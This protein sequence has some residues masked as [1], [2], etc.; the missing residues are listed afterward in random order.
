MPH[1]RMAMLQS[2]PS[3]NSLPHWR[4]SVESAKAL[5]RFLIAVKPLMGIWVHQNPELGNLVYVTWGFVSIVACRIIPQELGPRGFDT[6]LLWAPVFEILANRDGTLVFFLHGRERDQNFLY[7]GRFMAANQEPNV[8]VLEAEPLLNSTHQLRELSSLDSGGEDSGEEEQVMVKRKGSKGKKKASVAADPVPFHRLAFG[9]RRRLLEELA[10]QVRLPVPPQAAYGPLFFSPRERKP[11][12]ASN[13]SFQLENA[14]MAERR[15]AILSAYANS[16][17]PGSPYRGVDSV[18]L[19]RSMC[20]AAESLDAIAKRSSASDKPVP[21]VHNRGNVKCASP[22]SE[23]QTDGSSKRIGFA[24]FVRS[25]LQQIVGKSTAQ[26]SPKTNPLS[27]TEIKRLQFEEF[28]K[29]GKAVGLRLQA[30]TWR[31]SFY[32]AWPIMYDNRFALYKIPEQ[33]RVEGREHAGLWGGTFGWPP[34]RPAHAKPGS[35]LFFLLLS[36]DENE[37]GLHLIATKV[38]EGTHY[39][40]HPNGSAMFT[41][42]INEPSSEEFPFDINSEGSVLDIV[43]TWQGEGIANGYG[44]RYPGSK[45]GDLFEFRTGELAFVWRESRT[46]L[47]LQRIDLQSLLEK[48]EKVAA[49]PPI[50]NF[51]YLTKSYSNVFAGYCGPVATAGRKQ[52][53]QMLKDIQDIQSK[54]V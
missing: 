26:D 54:K 47:S 24:Q 3:Q 10:P 37:E 6:G 41:A 33:K 1:C 29:Q 18:A 40:L 13:D 36:Y 17:E 2:L 7:P 49:L 9:D 50:S 48:G 23:A 53:E 21:T 8:L 25:K 30:T 20:A 5:L 38:L 22:S 14:F 51:A 52:V 15:D 16:I 46:V 35:P 31:L 44:F 45:P 11:S 42:K 19:V 27:T 34:G 39:V 43:Q 4:S 28:L 32:R 12:L